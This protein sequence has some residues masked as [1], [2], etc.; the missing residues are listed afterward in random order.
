MQRLE[1]WRRR[2]EHQYGAMRAD[3]PLSHIAGHISRSLILFVAGFVFFVD[4]D[5]TH[6][7]HG[8]EQRTAGAYHHTGTSF[9]DKIPLVEAL[10]LRHAGMQHR[11]C[12]A[13]TTAKARNRLRRQ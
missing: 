9:A 2:T 12:V 3:H 13:E 4:D 8:G 6:V 5:N 7:F 11:H 1:R 10:T